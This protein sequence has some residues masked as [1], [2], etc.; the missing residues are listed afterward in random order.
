M[1]F[2]VNVS[3]SNGSNT[4]DMLTYQSMSSVVGF[5]LVK[6]VDTPSPILTIKCVTN[7]L[8]IQGTAIGYTLALK[9]P[10]VVMNDAYA[11]F[12]GV[13]VNI[14]IQDMYTTLECM[15]KG[16][17]LAAS[18]LEYELIAIKNVAQ[19]ARTLIELTA[20]PGTSQ[21]LV[22]TNNASSTTPVGESVPEGARKYK[23]DTHMVT[24]LL[25]NLSLM[26]VGVNSQALMYFFHSNAAS[27]IVF[28]ADRGKGT[29][30]FN[31]ANKITLSPSNGV[32]GSIAITEGEAADV[33]NEIIVNAAAGV[34][35]TTEKTPDLTQTSRDTYGVRSKKL[36]C[37]E[38][39]DIGTKTSGVGSC[40]QMA[41][42]V[43][44]FAMTPTTTIKCSCKHSVLQSPTG[45]QFVLNQTYDVQN[46][47]VKD[48]SKLTYSNMVVTK[49]TISWP[50]LIDEV[51]LTSAGLGSI[52]WQSTNSE[53]AQRLEQLERSTSSKNL[54]F[55]ANSNSS[56]S[57]Q[58]WNCNKQGS[59]GTM[60]D[61]MISRAATLICTVEEYDYGNCYNENTGVF[62]A[63]VNGV[64]HIESRIYAGEFAP[65]ANAAVAGTFDNSMSIYVIVSYN[66]DFSDF[67]TKYYGYARGVQGSNS[68]EFLLATDIFLYK[69]QFAKIGVF[70]TGANG[71]YY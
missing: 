66:E 55:R 67:T 57:L 43:L 29:G 33:F 12:T 35:N 37:T 8:K 17:L 71:E 3:D 40:Q 19:L 68:N 1:T 44:S 38:F 23:A 69:G 42:S 24:D 52:T 6:Q 9:Q 46:P 16:Y 47:V 15:G 58:Y 50:S 11:E 7:A 45:G 21:Y 59:G 2:Q 60:L 13:I 26:S 64:Y 22:C 70:A 51:E 65:L 36:S 53:Y 4:Y 34:Y 48:S 39:Y 28:L 62:E 27:N 56:G 31:V 25:K 32:I 30:S 5:T 10:I 20:I 18:N 54:M 49:Q 63:P 61:N 14:T 41:E